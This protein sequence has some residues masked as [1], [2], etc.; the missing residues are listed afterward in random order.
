MRARILLMFHDNNN[1]ILLLR[2]FLALTLLVCARAPTQE[3]KVEGTLD[4]EVYYFGEHPT[5][6]L[7]NLG[8]VD[9][10]TGSYY[11]YEVLHNDNWKKVSWNHL[12]PYGW[13]SI[14]IIIEPDSNYVE[15]LDLP[16]QTFGHYRF[17]KVITV[18]ERGAGARET[19][20]IEF[21]FAGNPFYYLIILSVFA[22][23]FVLITRHRR[24]GRALVSVSNG[25]T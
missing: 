9:V 5:F 19:I 21:R 17:C 11:W 6:T 16:M 25:Y 13:T 10:G 1:T 8:I 23:I 24:K 20:Y 15:S 22:G 12:L 4:K 14:L 7:K 3:L 2:L 18:E